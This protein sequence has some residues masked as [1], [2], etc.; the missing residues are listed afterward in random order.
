MKKWWIILL[1]STLGLTFC[2]RKTT[3]P[4][5][6]VIK[7][8]EPA[9]KKKQYSINDIRF[10][11]S[12]PLDQV[13]SK[14]KAEN[15]PIFIDFYTPTCQPCK[16]LDQDVYRNNEPTSYYFNKYYINLKVDGTSKLGKPIAEKY[17]IGAYPSMLFLDA[18]GSVVKK[19]SGMLAGSK[20][21]KLGEDALQIIRNR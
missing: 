6:T 16:W 13:I 19:H 3:S 17:Q 4:S 2:G 18:G 14:A 8:G 11:E 21:V 7:K 5:G 10:I 9:P 15:K 1:A 12:L 20:L